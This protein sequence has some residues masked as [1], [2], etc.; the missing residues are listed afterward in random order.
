[1]FCLIVR[2][3][4]LLVAFWL[5]TSSAELFA[6]APETAAAAPASSGIPY[7][8][9][10]VADNRDTA[11]IS[12]MEANSQLLW[13]REEK[14]DSRVAL[15]RRVAADMETA[16]KIL[17]SQGYYEGKATRVIEWEARPVRIRIQLDPGPRASIGRTEIIYRSARP[18]SPDAPS[19]AD[20]EIFP[21]TLAAFGLKEGDPATA[22]AVLDAVESIGAHLERRGYPL[23][24]T[25]NT[26][27]VLIESTHSL[28][29]VVVVDPGPFLR[30]G[31]LRVQGDSNVSETYLKRLV[32]WRTGDP[33]DAAS[34]EKYRTSL[35]ET[36]L[37]SMITLKP[38]LEA[39]GEGA[40]PG[41]TT[42]VLLTVTE[43]PPRTVSGGVRYS[44]DNGFG[45][46]ASWEHRNLLGG[47]ERLRVF[48]PITEDLQMIGLTF[49]KPEFGRRDQ[50]L[51][52]EVEARNETTDAYDQ[53]AGYAA[54][55]LERRFSGEWR[56][57][58]ASA[59]LS[60]EGGE[61]ND[62]LKGRQTYALFGAPLGLRRDTTNDFFNPTQGTRL[63]LS[64]TPYSGVYDGP[65][66]M[67]RARIDASGYL[68]PTGSDRLVLAARAA[69]G[70]LAGASASG[71]PAS[72]RFYVGGGGSVRGYKYQS[73]GPRNEKGDPTGGL[74]FTDFSLEAR[75]RV[76]DNFGIVPFLDGGMVYDKTLPDL[77]KKLDWGAGIGLRYYTPIGPV[78]LDVGVPL[79]DRAHQKAF[80]IY[81]SLGQ[82]F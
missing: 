6:A 21:R 67:V 82:A 78:R 50:S 7:A 75:F 38:D 35:Q 26:E 36:G 34:I 74:S 73:I 13:L 58:W 18:A 5:S 14:P 76:G 15:E 30:M 28:R 37:F 43:A 60:A 17:R 46:N 53:T 23:A 55:G 57:W 8:V 11:L 77:G 65:L 42:P 79:Q 16:R 2:T 1:M 45:V 69:A 19:F 25:V 3:L 68:M 59:R 32:P 22:E 81:L 10:F 9:T 52:A 51:V 20:G 40:A 70:S 64:V 71:T 72:L 56:H 33:W 61:I 62:H 41:G 47:G 27:Y 44:T 31:Q 39:S 80:Q 49:A 4:V 54:V 63:A 24:K 12:E 48:M 66:S 29:A